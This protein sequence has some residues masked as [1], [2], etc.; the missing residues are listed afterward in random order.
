[1]IY[2]I[3][4]ATH[5]GKTNLAQ[6][7]LEIKNIPYISQDHIKMGL[8]RTNNTN[9]TPED[10][11]KMVDF[12]WPITREIIKTVIENNQNLIVEGCY[13]PFTW[14]EDF[15][16]SYLKHIEYIC[17]CLSS[18]YITNHFDEIKSYSS[19]IERRIEDDYCTIDNILKFNKEYIDGC[20]KN[21]LN[22]ILIN[23]NYTSEIN[24]ALGM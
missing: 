20:E 5:S 7:L 2:I 17:L 11:D 15:D 23:E 14:K 8:I 12:L 3:T 24:K 1:M 4:G 9:L 6:R 21:N 19:C 10:D 16:E 18:K 22:Y 13:V